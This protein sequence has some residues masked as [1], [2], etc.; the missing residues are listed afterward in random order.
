[1]DRHAD[2]GPSRRAVVGAGAGGA[3]G[4]G[5][6]GGVPG[7]SGTARARSATEGGGERLRPTDPGAYV[8][9]TPRPGALALV[10][11][12]HALPI[13][14]DGGD[15]PGVLRVA[16][17]LRD[18]V[19]RVTGTRPA[20]VRTGGGR[21]PAARELVVLGT[22]GRSALVD[23]LVAR[24]KLD[25]GGVEGRWETSLQTIVEHPFPGVDRAFVIVGSDRRGTVFG[26]YDVSLGIGVSP[27]YW[28]DDVRPVHREALYVLPGRH[29]QGTPA[30]K[31]RGV[32]LNDENPALGTWA[33]GHFGPGKA[34]GHEGG[35]NAD[36]YARVFE[37][38]LRLKANYLWPAVWGRAFAEDDPEN[39]ARATRYGIVM[40][41]SHEAPMMRGIEEWNRHAV[42]AVRDKDGTIV[43]PGHDPYGGT[44]E[45]SFRNNAEALKKYWAD[46]IRRMVEQ[47]FEGVVTLGMRGNGDTGLPDGDGIDLMRE[48]IAT[49]RKILAD[50]T[51]KDV[52]TIPQVWT[53]YKEVQRYWDRGLRAP[54]DV[55]VVLTDDNWGNIR[56]H[57]DPA[58]PARPGGYGLYYHFDYVGVGRNYKWVDT[59]SL[60][61][62]WDQLRQ[63][64]AYGNHGLWVTNTGDLKGN[65]LPTQFFLDYAWNPDRWDLD[66]LPEWERRYARQNFGEAQ[67]GEIAS[68]LAEYARLQSLRKPE[69]L[70]RRITLDPDKDPTEDESAI[71]YDDRATPFSLTGHRELERVTARWRRL[72]E[73]AEKAA[74]RLPG[75][76]QDAFFELVGYEVLAT[77]NL[78]ALREAEFTNLLYAAQG[79][80]ATNDL[81][82]SAEAR[83]KDDF[84]LQDR[85]NTR[86]AG[87]KWKGFQTQPHIDY[88]DVER[89]GPNAP[90]Q[91]PELNNVAIPDVLFPAV[92][93]VEPPDRAE[94][95]VAVDGSADWWPHSAER[96]VLPEFSPHQTRPDQYIEVF[97]RGRR[98][99]DYR[100]TTSA[101]WLRVDRPHGRVEQQVRLTVSVD[102]AKAPEGR[103]EAEL[104]VHGPGGR[105]TTV[106]AVARRP[107]RDTARALR[108]FVEAGGYVAIDAEHHSRAVGAHGVGWQRVDGIGR[109]V[110]GMTPV[111]VTAAPRT[112]GGNAPRLEYEVSLLTPG[113]VTVWA[114]LSP[115]NP[116]LAHAGLRYAVSFDE[117]APQTVDV[118]GSTGADDGLMN[119]Q[120]ARHTSDN[121]NRTATRHTIGSAGV[122]R[123]TF[124]MVD[125]TVVLQRL[126]IDTGGLRPTYLGPPESRRLR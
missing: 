46:G 84:A 82:S 67:A 123:L 19:E 85:F 32:F 3:L 68:I 66:A 61:N 112:P 29:T 65:E 110:A 126:L 53:L 94:P 98:A 59:T 36:F 9:F 76:D 39:H 71:V 4:L 118:I 11:A 21:R 35:F 12:G 37:L 120:W 87:G 28:W 34:E 8:S 91:Q 48:I 17:D 55:T 102:W 2:R 100:V 97:N 107:D 31:Y 45:W 69:L 106:T 109:D 58:E 93:R 122:H 121:V 101:R 44:G 15:H 23:D 99:F 16:G 124:W 10:R 77:A 38:L 18:D 89:Y 41:T 51:G 117:D 30:V 54:E 115:R 79:R 114:Y 119:R 116:A 111:P 86:V 7:L 52:T 49:Q 33:P 14:V 108:G 47:D 80:A 57:P 13:A 125:P 63:A 113:E 73:R 27:W 78:Y 92:R 20:L 83:L 40:G 60:P 22:L 26:A 24:G 25:V 88:G 105:I 64:V 70:N 1:M 75:A 6:V 103:S 95:A 56:K 43:T 96:A 62:M 72:A 50:V 74:R 90:W 104:V 81:A 42:A 5:L